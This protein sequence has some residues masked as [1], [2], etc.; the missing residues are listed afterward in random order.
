MHIVPIWLY[1]TYF[2]TGEGDVSHMFSRDNTRWLEQHHYLDTAS[3][4]YL[5]L[6]VNHMY[7]H[8]VNQ[9]PIDVQCTASYMNHMNNTPFMLSV[10]LYCTCV[11]E[12]VC[13]C[14]CVHMCVHVCTCVNHMNNIPL[15]FNVQ[16]IT[17]YESHEQCSIDVQWTATC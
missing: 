14:A 1:T 12:C 10:Q 3:S 9:Y 15:M 8:C 13:V 4:L 16:L 2:M 11:Y 5:H 17:V 7:I 6:C